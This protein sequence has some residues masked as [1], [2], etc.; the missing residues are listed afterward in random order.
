MDPLDTACELKWTYPIFNLSRG[1]FRSCCRTPSNR[2]SQEELDA[3]GIDAFLNSPKQLRDRHELVQGIRTEDCSACWRVEESGATSF[4]QGQRKVWRMLK[5]AGQLSHEEMNS[6]YTDDRLRQRLARITSATDPALLSH[7][8]TMLEISL[9]NTCDM[10]CMYCN[11]HYSSQWG[12]EEIKLGRIT[13]EQYD[14][15]F[16]KA[17]NGFGD[18]FWEWF[19]NIGAG[20]LERIGIIGGEPLIMPEFYDMAERLHGVLKDAGRDTKPTLWIVT[21]MNTPLN[22]L[23]RFMEW[24]PRLTDVMDVEI[25]VSMESVGRRAE[26]IRNGVN[27]ERFTS[28]IDR[29]LERRDVAFDFG[30]IPT[31]NILS[32]T[33]LLDFIKF[34]EDLHHRHG[35][36]VAVKQNVV[37]Y[38]QVHSPFILTPDFA[39]HLDDVV[40]YMT[41]RIPQQPLVKDRMGRWDS[42]VEF[43]TPVAN[44]IRNNNQDRTEMRRR[45]ADW[46]DDFDRRRNLDFK[47]VFPEYAAFYDLCRST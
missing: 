12:A 17:P 19:E 8:P 24:F 35:K 32:I 10:K 29:I 23:T 33:S 37:S 27:W 9:G 6:Q 36:P 40:S 11:H 18:R 2:I 20:S 30:F 3:H 4:R 34:T 42:F 38:P 31:I 21:N 45:F 41:P 43:I 25:L 28:N 15:E 22:Y 46:V 47:Q 44:G 14:R 39:D 13:Q 16:P 5:D 1:E 26:Y 7:R